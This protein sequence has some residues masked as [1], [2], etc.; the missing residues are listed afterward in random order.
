MRRSRLLLP[1]LGLALLAACQGRPPE[2][3][4]ASAGGDAP[5][6]AKAAD[7]S[8][9]WSEAVVWDGDLNACRQGDIA[10][11][12]DCLAKAMRDGGASADA[13]AAAG[14]LSSAGELAYVTAWHEHDGLGVATV[15]YPFRANTNEG[16]RLVDASG[17]RIDVDAVQLDDALRADPGVQAVLQANP[18]ATP[19]PPAQ[20]AGTAPLDGGGIRL[21]YRTPLRD[22]HACPD[23]GHLQIGYDFDG[24]RNFIGQQLVPAAP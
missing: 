21:L 2:H 11:T 6:A 17:K 10:A 9:R 8:L 16:T 13:V 23:V 20:A 22:C 7:G 24:Q 14:Q 5:A 3:G 19:F 12:R 18:Q 1:A 4:A 15:A